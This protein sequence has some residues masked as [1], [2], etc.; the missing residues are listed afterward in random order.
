M[1]DDIKLHET[2]HHREGNMLQ[3][4]QPKLP[5]PTDPVEQPIINSP[6]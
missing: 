2:T 4:T 6:Y 5:H 3:N 1:G